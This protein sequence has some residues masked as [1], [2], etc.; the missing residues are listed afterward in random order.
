MKSVATVMT[1]NRILGD[2]GR[3]DAIKDK[4]RAYLAFLGINRDMAE[5]IN[6]QFAAH[7]E[8]VDGVRVANTQEWT[9]EA[10]RR[11]YRAAINK[12]VDSIIVQKSVADVPLFAHTP[13]GRMVLQFKSFMLASHQRVL[14]RGL[15]EDQ[16]RFVGGVLALTGVGMMITWLKAVSGGTTDKLQDIQANP[17]WWVAEGLRA[18]SRCRWNCPICSRSCR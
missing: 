11:A 7:G 17:G 2:V 18:S 12:D 14:L 8:S 6:R 5:R 9:D 4:E 1:Q 16:A 3:F 15:Q 10:A 13:T